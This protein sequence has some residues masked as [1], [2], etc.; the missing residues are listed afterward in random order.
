MF[1]GRE[2]DLQFFVNVGRRRKLGLGNALAGK[3]C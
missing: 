1:K 2:D 3:N